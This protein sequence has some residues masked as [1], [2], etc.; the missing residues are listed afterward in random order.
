MK[1][2]ISIL[3]VSV[4]FILSGCSFL[5]EAN[6]SINYATEATEYIN[7]LSTFAEDSSSLVNEAVNN[8]EAKAELESKLTSLQ[9]TIKEFN[10]IE[11]PSIA[12]DIH[13]N[14]EEKNQQL[15]DITDHVL[16]NGEV[17]VEKLKESEI[18]QTIDNITSLTNQI[19]KL[20]L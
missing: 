20:G 8:P 5:E 17:A 16:Q 19:E 10:K 13:K 9:D 15:L 7:E 2:L 12:E 1:K 6:N 14:V 4:F 11:A 18:Y 3:F